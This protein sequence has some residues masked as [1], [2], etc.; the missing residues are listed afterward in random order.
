M[1][2]D[3]PYP[4]GGYLYRCE[5]NRGPRLTSLPHA[6]PCCEEVCT[7][8]E[9]LGVPE[10]QRMLAAAIIVACA[11]AGGVAPR[12][13]YERLGIPVPIGTEIHDGR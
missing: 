5:H 12:E 2:D 13:H 7:L 1:K 6:M 4:P 8:A 9:Y 11:I 3:R 10:Q